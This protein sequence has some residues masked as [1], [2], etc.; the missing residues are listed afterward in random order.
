MTGGRPAF[1]GNP[2]A[3][4]GERRVLSVAELTRQIK[5]LL[6]R[7]IGAVWVEGELSNVRCPASGHFYFT[8]KDEQ[9]QIA[10]VLF[11]GSQRGLTCVPKDG[12]T[13]R[14]FGDV[15]VYEKGG[16]YQ[17]IVRRLEPGGKGALQARFEALKKK[18]QEEG[19][20]EEARKR[21]LPALTRHLGVV[22]SPTGA[23]I[24]DILNILARR[25]P[26]LHIVVAPCRVQGDGAAEEIASAIDLLNARGGLD[27]LIVGRGGGSAE[28]LWCFNEECVARAIA[29]SC[30]PVISAVGHETDFTISDFVADLRAPTP[31]AAAELVVG[32]KESFEETLRGMSLQLARGLRQTLLEARNRLL[33]VARGLAARD[34]QATLQ[35][36]RQRMEDARHRMT[37]RTESALRESLQSVD[38]MAQRMQHAVALRRQAATEHLARL[39][40]Q[41]KALNPLAVLTRGYSITSDERGHVLRSVRDVRAGQRL[42]SRL[43]DGRVESTA[44]TASGGNE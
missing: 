9:A 2:A 28:D 1:D 7:G 32:Q 4:A 29:R 21:R 40:S 17:I 24:R 11:R 5:S 39:K 27:A 37:R 6:E 16:N 19:L 20:F 12:L 14:V 10:G 22:T 25:F 38:D 15:S 8:I 31:S 3:A 23:A 30:I 34:P 26:N 18:L 36:V 33:T 42:F 13:V 35:R 41:M 44:A 43:S